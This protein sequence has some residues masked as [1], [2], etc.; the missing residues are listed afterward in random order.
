MSHNLD[1]PIELEYRGRKVF[2]KFEWAR[3]NDVAPILFRV[4]ESSEISGFGNVAAEISGP[5]EDYQT[6]LDDAMA[7]ARRWI[8]CQC[9]E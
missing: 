7:A 6:A 8:D 2:L 9:P 3:P 1:V 5:W 4:I